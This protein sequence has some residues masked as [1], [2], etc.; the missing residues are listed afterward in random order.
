MST[1]G[2]VPCINQIYNH[3]SEVLE[4]TSRELAHLQFHCES[5][6]Q[7]L[8]HLVGYVIGGKLK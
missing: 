8:A 4:F 2:E 3:Y 1:L 7:S 5:N 6:S